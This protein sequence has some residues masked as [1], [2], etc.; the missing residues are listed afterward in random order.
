MRCTWS[1]GHHLALFT[2]PS[3][4][5]FGVLYCTYT[6]IQVPCVFWNVRVRACVCVTWC[7]CSTRWEAREPVDTRC[8]YSGGHPLFQ[9]RYPPPR[10][11]SDLVLA[12]AEQRPVMRRIGHARRTGVPSKTRP[13][14]I[15]E[16]PS[17]HPLAPAAVR[18]VSLS[19]LTAAIGP[20]WP[21]L[22]TP[23]SPWHRRWLS[24]CYSEYLAQPPL[25]K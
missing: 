21:S 20:C 23:L 19:R 13:P 18:S 8:D 10:V 17:I 15:N 5:H 24:N 3:V 9:R 14:G 12:S 2:T 16:R 7:V 1:F 11:P 25:P 22:H 4:V 6:Y